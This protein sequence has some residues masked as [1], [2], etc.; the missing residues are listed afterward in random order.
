MAGFPVQAACAFVG[1]DVRLLQHGQLRQAEVGPPGPG[2]LL[3]A[4]KAP[5]QRRA[6]VVAGLLKKK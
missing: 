1:V 2:D 4:S 3:T 6:S 5:E